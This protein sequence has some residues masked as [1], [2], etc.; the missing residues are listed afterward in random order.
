MV[1]IVIVLRLLIWMP[2]FMMVIYTSFVGRIMLAV[3]HLLL[4]V[5]PMVHMGTFSINLM[6][7]GTWEDLT[8]I[9]KMIFPPIIKGVEESFLMQQPEQHK[10][11]N[12]IYGYLIALFS[13]KG[14]QTYL[15][16]LKMESP[17]GIVAKSR[18]NI[19]TQ[20][21]H[22]YCMW[23]LKSKKPEHSLLLTRP[24]VSST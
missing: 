4:M 13:W 15:S 23:H 24:Y 16:R 14:N 21:M 20:L 9:L 7:S 18:P 22:I 11:C 17:V 6:S 2:M 10:N 3:C 1:K 5:F 8:F 19:K 12:N